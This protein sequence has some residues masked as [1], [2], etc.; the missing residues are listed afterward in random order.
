MNFLQQKCL[1]SRTCKILICLLGLT[2]LIYSCK[3]FTDSQ[4]E[5]LVMAI[6][7][8]ENELRDLNN[9]AN[10]V[11]QSIIEERNILKETSAL[12]ERV[13]HIRLSSKYRKLIATMW[14][15]FIYVKELTSAYYNDY[16]G[17]RQPAFSR[18]STE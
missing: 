2:T 1:S 10:S 16:D 17:Q 15:Y 5:D 13:E 12:N 7:N 11:Q 3:H 18:C 8:V 14:H 4:K 6:D 9:R